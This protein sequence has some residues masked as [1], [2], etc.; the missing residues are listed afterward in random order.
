MA[1]K[2]STSS[3]PTGFTGETTAGGG[4]VAVLTYSNQRKP[5]AWTIEHFTR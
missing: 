4:F 1:M 3:A 2:L 5:T